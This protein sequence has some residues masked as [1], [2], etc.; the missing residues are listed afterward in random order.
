[1]NVGFI[2]LGCS[3]NQVDTE[4]M[5]AAVKKAGHRIVNSLDHAQAVIVNTCGFIAGAKEEAIDTL[6][7]LA[8]RKEDKN[9]N[10]LIATGCLA[11][12][13]GKELQKEIP[14]LDGIVGIASFT[15]IDKVLTRISQGEKVYLVEPPSLV[16]CETGP[17]IVSTPPGSA[18]LK[19]SEGCNNRCSFCAIPLI[20]GPF[21]SKPPGEVIAEA[22]A[23]VAQNHVKEITVIGQDTADYGR[24]L[25][26]KNAMVEV[27]K[28]LCDI[29]G[30][31]WIR[32][33]Y[34]HPAHISDELIETVAT[35]RKVLPYLD[36]PIQHAS[37]NILQAMNRKHG[38]DRLN[39]IIAQCRTNIDNLVLRTTVMVGF[40]GETE[41]DYKELY[42]FIK[43]TRFDWLGVFAFSAEEDTPAE[44][45]PNQVDDETKAIRREQILKLQNHIT[46]E[47]N[48]SRINNVETV[49][50]SN[51]LK[52]DLYV[53]RAYFQAPEVDGLTI[54]KSSSKLLPGQMVPVKYKAVRNYD[55]IG[56][57]VNDKCSQ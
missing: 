43:E 23:I 53:G 41:A 16:F 42:G 4:I 54:I 50:V 27:L 19:I 5:M 38:L 28:G 12:R 57:F 39:N 30:L 56:E 8:E 35:K 9:F 51:N 33:M 3:K 20:R 40:P 29:E 48:I 21:R 25:K 34:L 2:S 44:K 32:L 31:E 46:R 36:I 15:S 17:R 26:I 52:S 55:L 49:L 13:Y 10:Y 45:M 7:N 1:V 18:Y 24:D 11:Q 6:L 37:N 22:R 47:K 14:E